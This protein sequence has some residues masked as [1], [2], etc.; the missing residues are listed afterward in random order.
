[1]A[2]R[3]CERLKAGAE[4]E[5]E[6]LPEPCAF[7][8]VNL[9]IPALVDYSVEAFPDSYWACWPAVVENTN[10]PW[11][12]ANEIEEIYKETKCVGRQEFDQLIT[13]VRS[14]ADIGCRGSGRIPT[15]SPNNKSAYIYGER[16]MDALAS[17]CK[18]GIAS[19]PYSRDEIEAFFPAGYTINAMQVAVKPD[20][21]A[22]PVIDMSAPHLQPGELV[23]DGVGTSVN[24]GIDVSD[25]PSKMSSLEEI[26]AILAEIGC[27]AQFCKMDWAEAYKHVE[28]RREDRCLQVLGIG[29]K[30]FIEERITFGS[31]SSPGIFERPSWFLLRAACCKA[32]ADQRLI[33]KQID[34]AMVFSALGD[35]ICQSVYNHYRVLADR[36]GARLAPETKPDKAFPPRT[37][38]IALGVELDLEAWLWRLPRSKV[39]VIRHSLEIL[40]TSFRVE[41]P[42]LRTLVGRLNHYSSIVPG[43]KVERSFVTSL[44]TMGDREGLLEVEVT[45]VARAAA[46]WWLAAL[47]SSVEFSRI[48]DL[49]PRSVLV[50]DFTLYMDAAGGSAG[51]KN[52]AGGLVW[53]TGTWFYH[54][55]PAWLNNNDTNS[56]GVSFAAKLSFLE[57]MAGLMC[58]LVSPRLFK[59]RRV[60]LRSDNSGFVGAWR[61]KSG[62]DPYLHTII[63]ALFTVERGLDMELHVVKTKR[64]SDDGELIADQLSKGQIAKAKRS[65]KLRRQTVVPQTLMAWLTDPAP[66]RNLG[67]NILAEIEDDHC[68]VLWWEPRDF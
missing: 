63:H 21:K 18:A 19:G 4:M 20:G 38:G 61:S 27:P 24:S 47:P 57:A 25:F 33:T 11:L 26:S 68:S 65:G 22:R 2:R 1:M 34:D 31:S 8:K 52:G 17:W 35:G 53:E 60:M 56:Q 42:M 41:M 45:E 37:R 51:S 55:W 58:L 14:G 59:G 66:T 36:M 62:R 48:K 64:C 54:R 49:R 5:V 10:L 40:R 15:H 50:N 46:R 32:E 67:K 3:S 39:V 43:G 16:L 28:I 6:P 12:N 30:Y 44:Q 9:E 29:G 23:P 7:K 13:D